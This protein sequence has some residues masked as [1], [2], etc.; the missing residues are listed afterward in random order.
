MITDKENILA[1]METTQQQ[2][3]ANSA[4]WNQLLITN[5]TDLTHWI[6]ESG[7]KVGSFVSEQTPLLIQ[8]YLNWY[9]WNNIIVVITMFFLLVSAYI[10]TRVFKNQY[11]KNK[12]NYMSDWGFGYGLSLVIFFILSCGF[13]VGAGK[14]TTN[15]IKVKTSPRLVIIEKIMKLTEN[16]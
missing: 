1:T 13:V 5:L 16:K 12:D 7:D 10:L 11:L 2:V 9:F 15:C 3:T 14:A 6:K 8:E 4:D